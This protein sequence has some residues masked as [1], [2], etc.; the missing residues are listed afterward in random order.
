[1]TVR[2][3]C[4]CVLGERWQ[5]CFIN[6][7]LNRD[8]RVKLQRDLRCSDVCS[9]FDSGVPAVQEASPGTG[10]SGPRSRNSWPG[11][12]GP[13]DECREVAILFCLLLYVFKVLCTEFYF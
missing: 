8:G 10:A 12:Q 1:M 5:G 4:P 2:L 7:H 9:S 6:S 3:L 11:S 13:E